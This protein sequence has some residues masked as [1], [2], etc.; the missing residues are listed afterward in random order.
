M[1][2]GMQGKQQSVVQAHVTQLATECMANVRDNASL[3]QT[4]L[5]CFPAMKAFGIHGSLM[6]VA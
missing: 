1:L 2:A 3:L 5:V 4:N 6:A